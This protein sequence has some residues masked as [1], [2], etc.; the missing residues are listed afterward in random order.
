MQN[1]LAFYCC[2]LKWLVALEAMTLPHLLEEYL[3]EKSLK[4]KSRK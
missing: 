1:V 2:G 4:Q 3:D